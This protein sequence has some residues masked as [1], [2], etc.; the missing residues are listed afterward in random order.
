[1]RSGGTRQLRRVRERVTHRRTA[2]CERWLGDAVVGWRARQR[3]CDRET[4]AAAA[5]VVTRH[6]AVVM[7]AIVSGLCRLRLFEE[8]QAPETIQI[9]V[10]GHSVAVRRDGST[11]N[12]PNM[13]PAPSAPC[14]GHVPTRGTRVNPPPPQAL[15]A[16]S[17]GL[18]G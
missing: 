9:L 16:D 7:H 13:L 6:G 2:R 15:C 11:H 17:R 8:F 3:R 5:A 4:A 10:G 18:C 14:G 1:M 12:A